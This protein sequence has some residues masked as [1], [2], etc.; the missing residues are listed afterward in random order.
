MTR[1][2][3][4]LAFLVIA[5]PCQT[6]ACGGPAGASVAI[7][8]DGHK[9]TVTDIG[10]QTV[11]VVFTAYNASYNLQLAPGQSASPSSSGLFSQPMSGYQS[12]VATP[13]TSR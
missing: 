13:V 3:Q 12:C 8:Y 6:L 7:S 5:W 1:V 10:S 11:S 4:C 9:F 2:R